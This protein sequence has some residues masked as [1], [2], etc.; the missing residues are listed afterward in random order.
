MQYTHMPLVSSH[1]VDTRPAQIHEPAGHFEYEIILVT[2]G[3][4]SATIGHRTYRLGRGSLVFVGRL[5]SHSFLIRQVPYARYVS[6]FSSDKLLE[7]IRD[8]R[9][10]S[11]FICRPESFRH[12]I[13]L[14][15]DILARL[16][17][18]FEQLCREYRDQAPFY[19]SKCASLLNLLLIELYRYDP[20]AFPEWSN[21]S[22]QTAVVAAQRYMAENFRRPLTLGEVAAHTFVTPHTLSLAFGKTI[23][24]TFKEYLL[25]L[26]IAEAKRLL[27]STDLPVA[28]LAEQVGY[29]NVNNFIKIFRDRV[30]T[31][32]L[33]YRLDRTSPSIPE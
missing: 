21:S 9:L 12:V 2:Q 6:I 5:E 15:E 20:G 28:R 25:L 29:C 14:D 26:R 13:T 7:N 32:P 17:P 1:S 31:T 18:L 11:I 33:Q 4:V 23:G 24:M 8:N 3:E 30:G 10:L 22:T 16:E 27:V 19:L